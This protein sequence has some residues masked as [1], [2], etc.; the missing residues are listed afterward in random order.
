VAWE[1]FVRRPVERFLR[2]LGV[3]FLA[4]RISYH[5]REKRKS[6]FSPLKKSE[7]GIPP[8]CGFYGDL[9]PVVSLAKPRPTTG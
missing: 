5:S 1:F 9:F 3:E 7:S 4:A 8:G 6:G 2:F